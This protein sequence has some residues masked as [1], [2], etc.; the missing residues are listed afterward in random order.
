MLDLEAGVDLEEGDGA[1][2]AD[3]EFAR[4]G[5]VVARLAHDRLGCSVELGQLLIA[6]IGRGSFLDELLVAPLQGAVAR[7]DD[8]HIAVRVGEHLRLDVAG[9]VEIALDEA[10]AATESRH[11]FADSGVVELRDVLDR[12]RDLEAAAATAEGGLDGDRQAVLLREGDD[13]IGA[14]HG[15][16]GAGHLGCPS[17]CGDVARGDLVAQ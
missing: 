17:A 15:V 6:E 9:P 7:R 4:A 2:L 3:E 5:V 1:V 14:R 16:G 12:A 8:D 11:R 13:L 10:L